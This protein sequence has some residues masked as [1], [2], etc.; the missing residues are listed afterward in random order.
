MVY[1]D[2]LLFAR[3]Y[4]E[5]DSDDFKKLLGW[6]TMREANKLKVSTASTNP[7]EKM[8]LRKGRKRLAREAE[9]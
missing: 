8:D 4:L 3:I 9:K 5:L 7:R 6:K 1:P 2:V